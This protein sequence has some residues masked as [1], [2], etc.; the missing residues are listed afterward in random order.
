MYLRNKSNLDAF[1]VSVEKYVPKVELF[2]N[3]RVNSW[4]KRT[5]MLKDPDGHL[6]E[7]AEA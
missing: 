6:I 2:G 1:L 7:V 5:I 4:G 3:I